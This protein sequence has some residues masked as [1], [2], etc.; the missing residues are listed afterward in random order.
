MV[1]ASHCSK[2]FQPLSP[3]GSPK[4]LTIK[5]A[6]RPHEDSNHV[7]SKTGCLILPKFSVYVEGM[8]LSRKQVSRKKFPIFCNEKNCNCLPLSKNCFRPHPKRRTS[9]PSGR[10]HLWPQSKRIMMVKNIPKIRTV[11]E[12]IGVKKFYL[13]QFPP[14]GGKLSKRKVLSYLS[15]STTFPWLVDVTYF[16]PDHSISRHGDLE[17]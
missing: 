16:Y 6:A 2:N 11:F 5:S 12:K 9:A 15:K 10:G 3:R 1:L 8:T 13:G 4:R 17:L 7:F 14:K